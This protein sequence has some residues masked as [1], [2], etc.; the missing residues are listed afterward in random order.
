LTK[1][2]ARRI[3][4]NIAKLPEL[5]RRDF[6]A[7]SSQLEQAAARPDVRG[8][9]LQCAADCDERGEAGC[10][11]R[12]S[13][14]RR[15]NSKAADEGV[16]RRPC[17]VAPE[18]CRCVQSTGVVGVIEP[19]VRNSPLRLPR[20]GRPVRPSKDSTNLLR[21]GTR[22]AIGSQA[23]DQGRGAADRGERGEAA[24]AIAEALGS[25][26]AKQQSPPACWSKT[27]GFALSP[28]TDVDGFP[29]IVQGLSNPAAK[30]G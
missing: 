27:D 18:R 26:A 16:S 30:R 8:A 19:A 14:Q 29:G 11:E 9:R 24:G 21:G 10:W 4:A 12:S 3:A 20:K 28:Q 6:F 2:E 13:T 17:L 23:P 7:L 15:S 5:L 25:S 22:P 1:D